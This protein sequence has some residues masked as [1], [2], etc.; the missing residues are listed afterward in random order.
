M[1][2]LTKKWRFWSIFNQVIYPRKAPIY[3]I[4]SQTNA[5]WRKPLRNMELRMLPKWG[6]LLPFSQA[7]IISD[8]NIWMLSPLQFHFQ[9]LFGDELKTV[10]CSSQ[11]AKESVAIQTGCRKDVNKFEGTSWPEPLK[12]E[13]KYFWWSRLW[14]YLENICIFQMSNSQWTA[15]AINLLFSSFF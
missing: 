1:L 11:I 12:I 4:A 2:Q 13:S 6:P 15:A 9:F 10:S 14:K 5:L 3:W 7:R 8:E